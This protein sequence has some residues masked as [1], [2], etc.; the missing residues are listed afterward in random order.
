MS[1]DYKHLSFVPFSQI[2]NWSVQ[3][4]Q[5]CDQFF[6]NKY[7]C[8][9][10][11]SFLLRIKDPI[12]IVDSEN[13]KRVSIKLYNGGI[14][15]RDVEKGV[16]IGTKKQFL[17]KQGHLLLSKIDARNGAIGIVPKSCDKAIITGNFWDF[18]INTNIAE[19]EFLTLLMTNSILMLNL[20][21]L[22]K[23]EFEK[24]I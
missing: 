1:I 12:D 16:N 15:L 6:N 11:G 19:P 10:I 3:Y 21:I 14:T 20:H 2:Y 23:E 4:A 24:K 17:I 8:V 22:L 7:D 13:Y 5:K 18:E 9:K